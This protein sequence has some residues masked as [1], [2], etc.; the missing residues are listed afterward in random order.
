MFGPI[1]RSCGDLRLLLQVLT[2]STTAYRGVPGASMPR[3]SSPPDIVNLRIGLWLDD[4]MSPVDAAV[5]DV[6]LAA[7]ERLADAGAQIV[8]G[9][10]PSVDAESLHNTYMT[11]LSAEMSTADSDDDWRSLAEL[12][13]GNWDQTDDPLLGHARR[14]TIPHRL[15]LAADEARWK[16]VA[17]WTELFESVDCVLAPVSPVEPFPH[18]TEIPY[19]KRT[20]SVNGEELPYGNQLFWAGLATMPLLPAL[21]M[22]AGRTPGGLP[23]GMQLIGPAHSDHRLLSMG[24]E[25][26]SVLGNA[27]VAPP[28]VA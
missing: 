4:P 17:A 9:A 10:R 19:G 25:I 12:A 5:S 14:T 3:F 20:L 6:L 27:F 2:L 22:P 18:A 26:T 16:A 21:A 7:V 8:E 28:L 11:L 15:W 1:A 24:E 13:D 23:I